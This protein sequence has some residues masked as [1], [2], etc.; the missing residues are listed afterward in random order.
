MIITIN[1]MSQSEL[2]HYSCVVM[3]D[4]DQSKKS[5]SSTCSDTSQPQDK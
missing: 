4:G 3:E 5:P 1:A 2:W